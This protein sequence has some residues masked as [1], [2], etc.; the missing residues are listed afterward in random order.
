MANQDI[1]YDLWIKNK[2][3]RK[4]VSL[5]KIGE[6]A[7][8][9]RKNLRSR[10]DSQVSAS[11]LDYAVLKFILQYCKPLDWPENLWEEFEKAKDPYEG[12]YAI[13]KKYLNL[14]VDV[15]DEA[16]SKTT[17]ASGR[18]LEGEME[19]IEWTTLTLEKDLQ[20]FLE[21]RLDSI[22]NGLRLYEGGSEFSTE[23][24]TIDILGVDSDDNLVVI[25]IKK[26][27]AGDRAV[28]QIKRYM[29]CIDE[30]MADPNQ[31][32]RGMIVAQEFPD[33]IK[34]SIRNEPIELKKYRVKFKFEDKSF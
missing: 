2:D 25:E 26:G 28:G 30:N 4:G 24:G 16:Q 6:F 3:S 17:P 5:R 1:L 13:W 18:S 33:N 12:N 15:A 19:D 11:G 34:Y 31:G 29:G 32:V 21:S 9:K 27:K 8:R 10:T 7:E 23:A 20:Q 14:K 22:E